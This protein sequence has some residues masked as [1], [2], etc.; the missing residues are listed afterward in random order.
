MEEED[1]RGE[2]GGIRHPWVLSTKNPPP[3]H[4]AKKDSDSCLSYYYYCRGG[5]LTLTNPSARSGS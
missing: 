3:R 1:E 5:L 2:G 4:Y